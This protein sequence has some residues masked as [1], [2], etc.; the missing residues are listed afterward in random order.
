VRLRRQLELSQ[1]PRPHL[2]MRDEIWRW[3]PRVYWIAAAA[4]IMRVVRP[5]AFE[6]AHMAAMA[7]VASIAALA[8]QRALRPARLTQILRDALLR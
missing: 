6:P 1:Q 2:A 5:P 8:V 7:I 4:L 3:M